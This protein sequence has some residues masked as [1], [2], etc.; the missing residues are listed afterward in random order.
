MSTRSVRLAAAI[1]RVGAYPVPIQADKTRTEIAVVVEPI[2]AG[3]ARR[4]NS[5]TKE[6]SSSRSRGCRR[7]AAESTGDEADTEGTEGAG[8]PNPPRLDAD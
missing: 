8:R 5:T 2:S 7:E 1:R 6:T 4:W 3:G